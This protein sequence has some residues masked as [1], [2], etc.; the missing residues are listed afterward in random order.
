MEKVLFLNR[1]DLNSGT[2]L[3]KTIDIEL[4]DFTRMPLMQDV[5]LIIFR[6]DLTC[7]SKVLKNRQNADLPFFDDGIDVFSFIN[8]ILK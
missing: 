6:C 4:D 5:S 3:K 7:E 1:E 8:D 2:K